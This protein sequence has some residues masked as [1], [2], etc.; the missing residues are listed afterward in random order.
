[1][2]EVIEYFL[3]SYPKR[4][5]FFER[6]AA[7][8]REQCREVLLQN[9]IQHIVTSRAKQQ[10]RLRDKLYSGWSEGKSYPSEEFIFK[11]IGDLAGVRVALYFPGDR[12][13]ATSLLLDQFLPI[14][15]PKIFSG[16]ENRRGTE[17]YTYRFPGYVA[18]HL[19]VRLRPESLGKGEGS[20][21]D[22]QIEIQIASLVMHAWAEVEHDLVYKPFRGELSATEYALLDQANGLAYAT[23]TSLEQLQIAMRR[24]L[25]HDQIPFRNHYEVAAH[26]HTILKLP[27]GGDFRMGRAD[28]LLLLLREERIDRPDE[29][30][31]FLDFGDRLDIDSSVVDQVANRIAELVPEKRDAITARWQDLRE[32]PA[33]VDKPPGHDKADILAWRARDRFQARWRTLERALLRV[34]AIVEG[35]AR[36]S[37]WLDP[38]A[39]E[40]VPGLTQAQ[41]KA[42]VETHLRFLRLARGEP[43]DSA[44][45]LVALAD[46]VGELT[47]WLYEEFPE[48]QE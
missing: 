1:M 23:E 10:D 45:V 14:K 22:A 2:S 32:A 3:S 4:R 48:I 34:L 40:H 33:T 21:A 9:G 16:S 12:S 19:R 47:Q 44:D 20:Y 29:L 36:P 11:D 46:E 41:V 43:M 8:C 38:S 17:I 15:E 30:V 35:K 37:T 26:I 5:D 7:I 24:R 18:T 31:R 27:E 42:I 39:L 25:A 13:E 28:L 6:V